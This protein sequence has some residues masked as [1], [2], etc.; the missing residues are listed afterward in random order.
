MRG[1]MEIAGPDCPLCGRPMNV[2]WCMYNDC[3]LNTCMEDGK[4]RKVL[5]SY[6]KHPR[7]W[8]C[9]GPKEKVCC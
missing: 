5:Y 2:L 6:I 8:L 1:H 4:T 9:C 7:G 3:A